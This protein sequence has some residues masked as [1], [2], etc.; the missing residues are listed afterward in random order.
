RIFERVLVTLSWNWARKAEAFLSTRKLQPQLR[1]VVAVAFVAAAWPIFEDG[2]QVGDLAVQPVDPIFAI[3]WIL[4]GACAVGAAYQ[5]KYHR[6]AALILLGGAGLVTCLTFVWMS[7]PDLA[8]TQ[9]L[10]EI[11]TTV[12]LPLGLRWLPKRFQGS[13]A[14]QVQLGPRISRYRDFLL[15]IGSGVGVFT[16]VYAMMTRTVTNSI[17]DFFLEQAYIGGGGKNV[18]NVILVDFRA[19]DTFGE[20]AV[21]GIVGLTIY[22]LLRRFRP[23]PDTTGSTD[24]QKIQD[25]YDEAMPDRRSGETLTD[26]LAVPSVIMQW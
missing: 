13:D 18:V 12:L 25:A 6:L 11:V 19:F 4:G 7:A 8:V 5:A 22:A 23:A 20:I 21:L 3:L 17:G 16:I 10:V 24:Q 2:I 26:Y 14:E 1:I 9:L 15:A